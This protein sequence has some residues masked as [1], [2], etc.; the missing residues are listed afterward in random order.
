MRRLRPVLALALIGGWLPWG[1]C[2]TPPRAE[3]PAP[4]T[5]KIV[6]ENFT[7]WSWRVAFEPLGT[8]RA[9]P[10]TG[11]WQPVA[12]QETKTFTVAGGA[13]RLRREPVAPNGVP[14]LSEGADESVELLLVPGRTYTWPLAT[15][16][17]GD[18]G[19]P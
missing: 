19:R 13:Y 7:G 16:F 15:L 8:D 12:P 11:S 4:A 3:A 10:E 18:G 14:V 17:S 2:A 6:V 5:A 9:A 1:G